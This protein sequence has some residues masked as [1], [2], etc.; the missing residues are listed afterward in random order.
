M[1]VSLLRL[2]IMR[3]AAAVLLGAVWA[4]HAAEA[5]HELRHDGCQV[6]AVCSSPEPNADCGALLL[7]RPENFSM[8]VPA[9]AQL[10]G[11][12]LISE[13]FD[14]RAPPFSS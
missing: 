7:R 11:G 2:R 12:L 9:P 8:S 3:V 4:L 13:S 10:P 14:T 6:C 1:K 5:G